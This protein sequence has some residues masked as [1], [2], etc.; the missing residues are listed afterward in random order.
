MAGGGDFTAKGGDRVVPP[1]GNHHNPLL[2]HENNI[3]VVRE[4][5]Q[6]SA[7]QKKSFNYRGEWGHEAVALALMRVV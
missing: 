6:M 2:L 1:L 5:S 4:V 3:G 7:V